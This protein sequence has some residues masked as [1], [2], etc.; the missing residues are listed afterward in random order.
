MNVTLS[1]SLASSSSEELS[2]IISIAMSPS[3]L[4]E[5]VSSESLIRSNCELYTVIICDY[6]DASGSYE[7]FFTSIWSSYWIESIE[8]SPV[9][10]AGVTYV[11]GSEDESSSMLSFSS[12]TLS[13]S[14]NRSSLVTFR[15]VNNVLFEISRWSSRSILTR[16]LTSYCSFGLGGSISWSKMSSTSASWLYFSSCMIE[17]FASYSS[18]KSSS[19][20]SNHDLGAAFI[21]LSIYSSLLNIW[22]SLARNY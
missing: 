7:S 5:S 12:S 11:L 20:S 16:I 15:D 6:C 19:S 1:S 8:S 17:S 22:K 14:T 10:S 13:F 9:S 2:L 18:S 21:S 3:D 4:P